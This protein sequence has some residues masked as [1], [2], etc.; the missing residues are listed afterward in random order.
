MMVDALGIEPSPLA[1]QASA[2]TTYA[3]RPSSSRII[4][5]ETAVA[6]LF[7]FPSPV[8]LAQMLTC[9]PP[10]SCRACRPQSASQQPQVLLLSVR[11]QPE[12]PSVPVS[13]ALSSPA[14]I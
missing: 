8:A 1:L 5:E 10:E 11:E 4:R 7:L 14:M 6:I 12:D 2:Q 3:R 13:V 9:V